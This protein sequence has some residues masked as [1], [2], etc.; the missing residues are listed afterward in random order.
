MGLWLFAIGATLGVGPIVFPG[1]R[2]WRNGLSAVEQVVWELI[3]TGLMFTGVLLTFLPGARRARFVAAR[4]GRVCLNCGF[5]LKGLDDRGTCPEC[6]TGYDVERNLRRFRPRYR[7][8]L[9]WP[10]GRRK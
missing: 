6:G 10:G 9:W 3:W 8:T 2:V 7:W 1:L 4:N 5:E